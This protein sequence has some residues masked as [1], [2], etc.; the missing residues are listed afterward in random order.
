MLCYVSIFN[1]WCT[2]KSKFAW[3]IFGNMLVLCWEWDVQDVNTADETGFSATCWQ[4][5]AL[6][7][8][9]SIVLAAIKFEIIFLQTDANSLN[10]YIQWWASMILYLIGQCRPFVFFANVLRLSVWFR[11][12]V[13]IRAHFCQSILKN[14]YLLMCWCR[15]KYVEIWIHRS[16]E[17][18]RSM[19]P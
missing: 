10:V 16:M 2:S 3:E 17:P 6:Y 18:Y 5:T 15:L 13:V 14:L 9:G 11:D 8:N 4:V 12:N 19:D 1:V 7:I